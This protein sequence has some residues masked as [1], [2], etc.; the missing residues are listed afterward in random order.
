MGCTNLDNTLIDVN[1]S[2]RLADPDDAATAEGT[3]THAQ[4]TSEDGVGSGDG[5]TDPGGDGEVDG[6]SNDSTGHSQ[7]KQGRG[8]VEGGNI[9]NLGPDGISDTTTNTYGA[10]K[11]EDGGTDHSLEVGDGAGRDGRCPRV[12][13]I[14]GT[15]VP[16]V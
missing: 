9:N 8:I 16:G 3:D 7:H 13:H 15:D 1:F 11:L 10:G 12:G 4:D 5:H 14:V 2:V 6:G